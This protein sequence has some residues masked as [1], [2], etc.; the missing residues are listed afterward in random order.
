VGGHSRGAD[1]QKVGDETL[2]VGPLD[3]TDIDDVF[4]TDVLHELTHGLAVGLQGTRR[5]VLGTGGA[6]TRTS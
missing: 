2:D 5:F 6:V 3:G 1:G 4:P